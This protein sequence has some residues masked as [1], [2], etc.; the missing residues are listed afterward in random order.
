MASQR[1]SC[2]LKGGMILLGIDGLPGL[3]TGPSIQF[4]INFPEPHSEL[5]QFVAK[6]G[7]RGPAF[8]CGRCS[9]GVMHAMHGQLHRALAQSRSGV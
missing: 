4:S 9:P 2:A 7:G 6:I 3:R 5:F 8:D 1:V